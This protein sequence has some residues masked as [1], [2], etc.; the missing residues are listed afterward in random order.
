MPAES[1]PIPY[2]ETNQAFPLV[3]HAWGAN[4][5]APG[6]LC[7]G[8]ALS[9]DMLSQAYQQ[10]IFPWFSEG[11]PVLWWSPDPRM[12]LEVNKF[13]LKASLR[14]VLKRFA[15]D[16]RCEIRIDS[17]F[18]QVITACASQSRAG[19]SGTW[20]LPSMVQAYCELHASG[21]AHSVETWVDGE[22]AGGLYCVA[23]GKAVFGESMFYW[24]SNASKIALSALVAMGRSQ[25]LVQIDCQQN[26]AHLASMGAHNVPR[27]Q[28]LQV[29]KTQLKEPALNWFFDPVYWENLID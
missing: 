29:M 24:R 6:L 28:F 9:A 25:G 12:V 14:K 1:A 23:I 19:Q 22:L 7:V 16:S 10:G 20:I 15:K 4:S 8:S 21:Q 13:T 17:A 5:P 11:Q 27:D 26:T 18:E 3:S 2:I